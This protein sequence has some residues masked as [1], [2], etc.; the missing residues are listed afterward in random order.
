MPG[1]FLEIMSS[2]SEDYSATAQGTEG[3]HII[4]PKIQSWSGG[5][6][7]LLKEHNMRLVTF[8]EWLALLGA[9]TENLADVEENPA[10]QLI[11]SLDDVGEQMQGPCLMRTERV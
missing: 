10:V 8:P 1:I 6:A 2:A 3:F 11:D 4:K 5:F 9:S 7:T